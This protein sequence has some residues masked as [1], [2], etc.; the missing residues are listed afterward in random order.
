MNCIC[1]NMN[2]AEK[3][4]ALAGNEK[5][6]VFKEKVLK[7]QIGNQAEKED[8]CAECRKMGNPDR[9]MNWSE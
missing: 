1:Y 9:E 3:S 8:V 4:A 7:Y 2:T 6:I 5:Y